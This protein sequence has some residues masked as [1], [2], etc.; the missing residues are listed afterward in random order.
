[1]RAS[2]FRGFTL[3]EMMTAIGIVGILA[4]LSAIALTKL[5]TRGNFA[6]GS[7]DFVATLRTARAEA[8]ARGDNTVVVIDS[9]GGRWWAIEDIAGNFDLTAFDPNNPAPSPDRLIYSSTLPTGTSFG[10]ANGPGQALAAPYSGIPT[11]YLNIILAD[12]GNGGTADISTDGGT[13]APNFKYCSFCRK[14]DGYGAIT[15]LSSGGA[16]FN[17][18]GP[19]SVGHQISMQAG[20][21]LS[22]GGTL[23]PLS[24]LIDFVVVGATGAS[25]AVTIK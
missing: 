6:S 9:N 11:G 4:G 15:F 17:G 12:G 24:G 2:P 16:T 25:E 22:D 23:D 3:I 1:M 14:S 8:F 5:K 7:G 18:Q 20:S 19:L 21:S 10:P 13:A